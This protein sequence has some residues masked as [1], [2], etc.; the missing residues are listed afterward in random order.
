MSETLVDAARTL[1][2]TSKLK[3]NCVARKENWKSIFHSIPSH[4]LDAVKV[5]FGIV[6]NRVKQDIFHKFVKEQGECFDRQLGCYFGMVLGDA[7]GAPIEFL[8]AQNTSNSIEIDNITGEV[9]YPGETYNVFQLERGQWTDDA[10]MGACIAD[11]LIVHS[12]CEQMDAD[13][14]APGADVWSPCYSGADIRSRFWNWSRNSYNNAFRYYKSEQS[15]LAKWDNSNV[16]FQDPKPAEG[17]FRPSVGLGGNISTSLKSLNGIEHIEDV[18]DW[19]LSGTDD[20]GNGGIM[21]LASISVFFSSEDTSEYTSDTNLG[22]TAVSP[23]LCQCMKYARLSSQTTH[24]GVLASQAAEF[25]S[26]ACTRAISRPADDM[27]TASEFIEMIAD[28][29]IELQCTVPPAASAEGGDGTTIPGIRPNYGDMVRLLRGQEGPES[30]EL[31]WN[32]RHPQLDIEECNRIRGWSYNGIMLVILDLSAWM[33]W[34]LLS[35]VSN[36]LNQLSA[37]CKCA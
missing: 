3:M 13:P 16:L 25:L 19:Y 14:S 35:I 11:S 10:S 6:K 18:P 32:W 17:P 21:R 15:L 4:D 23:G 26:F 33:A 24:P 37:V 8:P 9:R 7:L 31:C 1:S 22:A 2:G 5:S 20:S 30:T 27:L 29:F 12:F 28:D 34:Q 36:I